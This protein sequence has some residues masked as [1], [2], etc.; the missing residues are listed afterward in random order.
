MCSLVKI[1][2]INRSTC[3]TAF[4]S[5]IKLVNE[6]SIEIATVSNLSLL[7]NGLSIYDLLNFL[8]CKNREY[9]L[10]TGDQKLRKYS[11]QNGV[12]VK[13]VLGIMDEMLREK[14]IT[15]SLYEQGLI[16]LLKNENTRL[17]YKEIYKR[18]S[19]KVEV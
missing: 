16:N 13:G 19:D 2:E 9:E 1:A 17:P 11:E 6:T 4:H 12:V 5:M 18:I 7:P 3:P 10:A 8:V 15:K 14:I